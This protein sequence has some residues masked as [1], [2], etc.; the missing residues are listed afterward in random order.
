MRAQFGAERSVSGKRT[1]LIAMLSLASFAIAPALAQDHGHGGEHD[2]AHAED[3]H[4]EASHGAG[5]HSTEIDWTTM[6]GSLVNFGIWLA[7]L[8]FMLRKPLSEFLRNRRAS[9]LE[10]MEEAKRVKGEA[11]A[12]YKEY[13]ERIENLDAELERL[14]EEMRRAGQLER[15]KIVAAANEKAAKMRSEAQ[16]LIEQ[17]MKQLREDLTREAIEAAVRTA[18]EVLAKQTSAADQE[19]LASDYLATLRTSLADKL[20]E[21]PL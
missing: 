2:A 17:Q 13:S 5:A 20:K 14:R 8:Y 12:K 10:G 16:F 1:L 21:R 11:E 4:G 19:R 18:G 7:L 6:S 15:E 3:G 9:V